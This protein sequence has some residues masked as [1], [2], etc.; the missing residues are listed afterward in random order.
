MISV[1]YY[2]LY[3]TINWTINQQFYD[4]EF[5]VPYNTKNFCQDVVYE[6]LKLELRIRI[7]IRKCKTFSAIFW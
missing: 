2:I 4:L 1:L 3:N 6:F 7:R 5:M